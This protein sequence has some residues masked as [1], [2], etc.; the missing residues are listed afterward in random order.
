M[1]QL[2]GE[3]PVLFHQSVPI[4]SESEVIAAVNGRIS[5]NFYCPVQE[6]PMTAASS[7]ATIDV[8]K[9]ATSTPSFADLPDDATPV[10]LTF[11]PNWPVRV[12][13]FRIIGT[14]LIIGTASLWVLPGVTSASE[15]VMFKLGVS[16]FFFFCGLALLMRNHEDNQPDAYFD[17]IRRE[18]RVLQMNDRGRP[19][20]VLR[21]SYDSLG[22]ADFS[23]KSVEL[24]DTDGCLI[25]RL[26]IDDAETRD[27]LKAQLGS[28][29]VIKKGG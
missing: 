4:W 17:P 1:E 20:A 24:F 6:D 25:M 2:Y 14:A 23:K 16:V 27:A 7:A 11:A 13:M 28:Q 18:V 12:V 3:L 9:S 10:K 19:Q 26:M 21:C 5:L 8:A 15:L 29:V 22:R